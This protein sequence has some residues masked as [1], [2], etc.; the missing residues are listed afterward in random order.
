VAYYPILK[1][2]RAEL[3]A[4]L[5]A[6][7]LITP[8]NS[9]RP[10]IEPVGE[11]APHINRILVAGVPILLIANPGVGPFVAGLNPQ[12][13]AL[14]LNPAVLPTLYVGAATTPAD[15]TAF[16]SLHMRRAFFFKERPHLYANVVSTIASVAPEV[17]LIRDG[18]ISPIAGLGR[19][20]HVMVEDRFHTRQNATYA[21]TPDEFFTDRHRTILA[22]RDF[23]HFGDYSIVGDIYYDPDSVRIPGAAAIHIVYGIDAAPSQLNV[24]HYVVVIG[25]ISRNNAIIGAIQAVVND[26]PRIDG[27][28]AHNDTPASNVWQTYLHPPKATSF[29]KLKEI[30]IRHHLE[31]MTRV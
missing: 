22:N 28:C 2:L 30:S 9:V 17:I 6:A 5:A 16:S 10:V 24:H 1:G 27:L 26:K 13:Q 12:H 25:A 29:T 3:D 7:P 21:A 8:G 20:R 31:L 14:L 18:C 19:D 15:V 11:H 4:V 23:A